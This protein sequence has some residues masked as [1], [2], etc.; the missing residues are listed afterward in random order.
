MNK[1]IIKFLQSF[2]AI[3]MLAIAVPFTGPSLMVQKQNPE[4]ESSV[5]TTQEEII[6]KKQGEAI[7]AYF[8]KHKLPLEGYGLKFATEAKKNEIDWRL[9]PAIAMRES[10][11]GKHA[12][13]KVENSVFGYGS[14]KMSFE[15]IDKS[16][17]IVSRSLGGNHPGTAHYYDGK[18]TLEI[19]RKY[20]SVIPNYPNQV[21]KIMNSID[22]DGKIEI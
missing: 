18:T 11:G 4:V 16:I 22:E 7:D 8:A 1:Q 9:L 19:L 17:E 14:C 13:K 5:I 12:C 15:S 6:L 21:V 10:T 2:I 3:P 20:N